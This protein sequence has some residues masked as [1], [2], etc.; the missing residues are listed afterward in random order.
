M[1][2]IHL[3]N[4]SHDSSTVSSLFAPILMQSHTFTFSVWMFLRIV[5]TVDAHSG[6]RLPFV[7]WQ[8]FDYLQVLASLTPSVSLCS[9][10]IHTHIHT[11]TP[12]IHT[13]LETQGGAERHDFHHSNFSGS[14]GSFFCF[15]DW[16]CGTDVPYRAH[17]LQQIARGIGPAVGVRGGRI[18]FDGRSSE[19]RVA[20][21]QLATLLESSNAIICSYQSRDHQ[22]NRELPITKA[23]P[24]L[25]AEGSVTLR[26]TRAP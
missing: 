12:L 18:F 26:W 14:Y 10:I 21:Q 16:L 5:E 15:W 7:P 23:L 19:H 20:F 9:H 24:I 22:L 25:N 2:H 17:Q 11:H 1:Q 8:M 4:T 3:P 13:R 6:Y